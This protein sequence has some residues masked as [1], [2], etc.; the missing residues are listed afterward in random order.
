MF[1]LWHLFTRVSVFAA[2][3]FAAPADKVKW[4]VKSEKELEK[5]VTLAA[6][7]PAFTCVKKSNTIECIMAIKVRRVTSG[8]K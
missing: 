3:V 5:C 6:I 8:V 7:A 2:A 4:C 1:L